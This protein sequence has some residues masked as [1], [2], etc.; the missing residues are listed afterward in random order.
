[1]RRARLDRGDDLESQLDDNGLGGPEDP[2]A[3]AEWNRRAA[4]AG[5]P[6]GLFNR[7]LDLLRGRGTA[8]DP[9][10][11]RQFVDRAAAAGLDE[12]QRL[13]RAGYD[14]REVTPDADEAR[15][16]PQG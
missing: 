5:D 4:A 14:W 9:E 13:Q 1:M 11:G 16:M 6:V 2:A 10:A 15:Y 12:A 3:A 8:R 7:G